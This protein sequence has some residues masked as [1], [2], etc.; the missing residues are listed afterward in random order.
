MF[1]FPAKAGIHKQKWI[2]YI[3]RNAKVDE[4]SL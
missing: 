4:K 2:P 1:V 3:L